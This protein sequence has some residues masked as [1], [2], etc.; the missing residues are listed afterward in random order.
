LIRLEGE[1]VGSHLRRYSLGLHLFALSLTIEAKAL[2]IDEFSAFQF[3][4]LP[5]G[6]TVVAQNT[7]GFMIGGVRRIMLHDT[8]AASYA[9]AVVTG[10]Q[11]T[12]LTS[13]VGSTEFA[14][15]V[16]NAGDPLG[17]GL[18]GVDLTEGGLNDR[19]AMQVVHI[20]GV[21]SITV[22]VQDTS[23]GHSRWSLPSPLD[24]SDA[25]GVAQVFFEAVSPTFPVPADLTS[26]SAI[27]IRLTFRDQGA[28]VLDSFRTV[29]EPTSL[30]LVC[31]GLLVLSTRWIRSSS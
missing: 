28:I 12:Y 8:A 25:P 5:L 6:A 26:V 19:F 27:N 16:W 21:I 7:T 29:P 4:E 24:S 30:A 17:D 23:G 1:R 20:D 15:V 11:L 18:G 13:G 22:D 14:F 31:L 3:L 10:G 2:S 9:S